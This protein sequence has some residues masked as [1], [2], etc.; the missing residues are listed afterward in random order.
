MRGKRIV[1]HLLILLTVLCLL[2]TGCKPAI[3]NNDNN[4]DSDVYVEGPLEHGLK[5]PPSDGGTQPD[6]KSIYCAYRS[7]TNLFDID[8]VTL[9]FYY[10]LPFQSPYTPSFIRLN[11]YSYPWFELY[12][13]AEDEEK[14]LV[15]RVDENFVSRKYEC[16]EI[17]DETGYT[18]EI[19]F[20]HQ[21][22]L[23]IPKEC[24][25]KGTGTIYFS[26]YGENR[27]EKPWEYEWI[28][29]TYIHYKIKDGKV[30]LSD[31]EFN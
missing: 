24:F 23:T 12:F 16:R 10:G 15:K 30:W 8:N 26:I 11:L 28:I 1:F 27:R 13:E 5:F 18:T 20:R 14:I 7:D 21:E 29:G 4:T 9:D 2:I 25:T 17:R 22:T 3:D 31:Q 6:R 19:V